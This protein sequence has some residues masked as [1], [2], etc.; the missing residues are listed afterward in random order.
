MR[1]QVTTMRK[2]E[3][4]VVL[5]ALAALAGCSGSDGARGPAG[6]DGSAGP[7]GDRGKSG[8]PGPQGAPGDKGPQGPSGE[9]GDTAEALYPWIASYGPKT[10]SANTIL[11]LRGENFARNGTEVWIGD[12]QARVLSVTPT[13]I[14]VRM[15]A[16]VECEDS[17]DCT[18]SLRV[19]SRGL[20]GRK[21]FLCSLEDNTP[22]IMFIHFRIRDPSNGR[23]IFD[24]EV[25]EP[26]QPTEEEMK[27]PNVVR[28][29]K[30]NFNKDILSTK[31][32][33]TT[34]VFTVGDQPVRNLR[35]IERHY[36]KDK[37]LRSFDFTM[38]FCIPNST[39]SWEVLYE[40]PKLKKSE[41]QDI[42]DNP[43]ATQSDSF[44]FINDGDLIMHNRA[45]YTY[46]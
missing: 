18:R 43:M 26:V 4:I 44:Y 23:I 39:N 33:G 24:T 45:F 5:T 1:T 19:V 21:E 41:L 11:T 2:R 31:Q 35:M 36:F 32:I 28:T 25:H 8:L 34:L 42:V 9:P 17:D 40:L 22:E 38:P 10:I 7:E 16:R 14:R 6:K 29:I 13:E 15:D 30:Y 46:N 20:S 27:D 3:W 37:L 12:R